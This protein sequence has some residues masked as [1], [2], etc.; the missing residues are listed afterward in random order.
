MERIL[1]VEMDLPDHATRRYFDFNGST[2]VHPTVARAADEALRTTFGNASASHAAGQRAR[3][4]IERARAQVAQALGARPSEVTFTSGGTESNNWALAGVAAGRRGGH[5]VISAIEHKSVLRAAERLE[6]QGVRVTRVRPRA[7]G[8][9]HLRDV[10]LALE[11]DTFLVSVMLANNETG[12]VQPAREIARAC[13]ERGILFHTDA[14]CVLGKLPIDVRELGCDLL[15]LSAHKVYAPKGVGA[16]YV[17]H[18]V[19]LEPLVVGCGQQDGRRSGTE[20]TAGVVALGVA[21]D[22]W[23]QGQLEPSEPYEALR[24]ILWRGI[25]ERCPEARLNG[26]GAVLPGT[27]NV[28]FP[29]RSAAALQAALAEEGFSVS[30]GAAA[31]TGNPSHVLMAM[32]LGE[33]RARAS[34]R[35]S[36]GRLSEESGVRELLEALGALLARRAD[37]IPMEVA[38]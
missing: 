9:V 25:Q 28:F 15:S 3:A 24:A 18:G 8:A 5:V 33:E 34:L 10:E 17:R 1:G 32:G 4:A 21:L 6:A 19:P 13:R 31:S 27:L 16:L 11:S 38:R 36:L 23:R 7:T 37:R 29:G 2:P 35:F 30:A 12:V 14:V 26:E 20:N 22:L